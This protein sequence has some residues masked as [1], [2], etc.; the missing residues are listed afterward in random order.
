MAASES[1]VALALRGE[2]GTIER[3]AMSSELKATY[4]ASIDAA[5]RKV[6]GIYGEYETP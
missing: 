4:R 2:A 3:H 1:S 6:V 5:G